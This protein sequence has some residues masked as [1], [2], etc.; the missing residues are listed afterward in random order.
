[1][2]FPEQINAVTKEQ[3]VRIANKYLTTPTIVVLTPEA[4]GN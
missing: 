2:R 1:V 3:L 4:K